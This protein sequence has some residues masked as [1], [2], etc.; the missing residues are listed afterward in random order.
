MNSLIE[1]KKTTII[2]NKSKFISFAFKINNLEDI[3]NNINLVKEEYK[4][5]THYCYAYIF[6]NKKKCSDDNEPGGTAGMPIL[7]VLEK[8]DLNNILVVVVRYFGGIKLGAGG[9]IRV[10]SNSTL[11]CLKNNIKKLDNGYKIEITFNYDKVKLIDSLIKNILNKDFDEII[12]YTFIISEDEY[13][14]IKEKLENICLNINIIDNVV[15]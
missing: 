10:Y 14:L 11:E 4:D 9:L 7:N 3:N 5:A 12:K 8:N 6:E 15:I 1:N 2:I 13:N